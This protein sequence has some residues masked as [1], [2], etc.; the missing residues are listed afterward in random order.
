[1]N[2]AEFDTRKTQLL[3]MVNASW[4]TQ[5]IRAA[6]LLRIPDRL[7]TGAATAAELASATVCHAPSLQRLLRALATL[8]LCSEDEQG[9]YAVTP[10]GELL[11]EAHAQSVRAWALLVGGSIWQRWAELDQSVR[12]G[13]SHRRR[14]NGDDGFADLANNPAA[15]ALFNRAMVDLTRSIA[16]A[17][18]HAI[19]PAGVQRVVDVGGGSGELLAHVLATHTSPRGV[20]FDLPQGLEGA[21]AVLERAGVAA[22]CTRVA[23]SFFDALPEGG[24][25]YLLKSVLHNWD[26][27]RCVRILRN[28]RAAM[29]PGGRVCVIER[30]VSDRIGPSARDRAVARSDLNMLVALSG[31]ERRRSEFRTLFE[32]AGLAIQPDLGTA[33]EFCILQARA[34]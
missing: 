29:T 23:G 6:C 11:C 16:G 30:V 32:T 5:A 28:C 18:A 27:E 31:R 8:G 7:A 17:V 19:D 21:S 14:H 15:A 1:M 3:E 33:G 10:S 13:L 25:L 9:R 22:R 12:T 20:L 26:D 2:S 24:D 34:A 4:M